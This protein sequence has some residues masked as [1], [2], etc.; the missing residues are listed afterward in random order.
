MR[1][2]PILLLA[3]GLTWAA[4]ND[5]GSPPDGGVGPSTDGTLVVSTSTGLDLDLDGYRVEVDGTDRGAIPANDTV[6]I[7]LD[8]GSRTIA[9]TGLSPNCTIEGPGSRTVTIVDTE[10]ASIDFSVVC[11]ATPASR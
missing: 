11:T 6:V 3:V 8:P 9:L 1:T 7:R 4:C 10:V 2:H 5:T